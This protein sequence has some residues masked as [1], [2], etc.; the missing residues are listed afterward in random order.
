M[1]FQRLSVKVST[2][3]NE[4]MNRQMA[5]KATAANEADSTKVDGEPV[6]G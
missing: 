5:V 3:Q 6:Y 2:S 4:G 1:I